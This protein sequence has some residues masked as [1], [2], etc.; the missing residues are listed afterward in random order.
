MNI[1]TIAN[2]KFRF[3]VAKMLSDYQE[4]YNYLEIEASIYDF[5]TFRLNLINK[6]NVV[7]MVNKL[8][9]LGQIISINLLLINFIGI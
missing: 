1:I 3:L 5:S 9:R 8:T 6:K 4:N 2:T 7:E